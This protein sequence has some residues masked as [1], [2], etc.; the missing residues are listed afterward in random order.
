[1]VYSMCFDH[2]LKSI[3]LL[4]G[5][6]QQR[7]RQLISYPE[8]ADIFKINDILHN[9]SLLMRSATPWVRGRRASRCSEFV[10]VNRDE[11]PPLLHSDHF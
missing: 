10:S 1:M 3:Y 5:L 8:L 7:N 2:V 9:T 11:P 4:V 6:P